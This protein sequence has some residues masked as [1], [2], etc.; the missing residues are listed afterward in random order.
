MSVSVGTAL[1]SSEVDK[2]IAAA[3]TGGAA[4]MARLDELADMKSKADESLAEL[5]LATT[6]VEKE[7]Q[8][9]AALEEAETYL[10]RAKQAS[11]QE[12]AV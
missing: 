8:T 11:E 3:R 10:A 5:K 2:D 9:R 4:F 6:A 7:K 1:Q 12:H